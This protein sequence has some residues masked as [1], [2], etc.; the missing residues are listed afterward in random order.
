MFSQAQYEAVIREIEN[1][2]RTLEAKLAEVHPAARKAKGQWWITPPAAMAIEW[3]AEKTVEVGKAILN[4]F[5]DLLKGAVAPIFMFIDAYHWMDIRGSANAVSTDLT[6][7][8]LVVDNSDW[9]GAGHDAYLTTAGA[10]SSAASRVGSIATSTSINL[11]ACAAA[12]LAFY[13]ALAGVLAKL[14]AALAVV[15]AA[16]GSVVFSWAGLALFLEEAGVNTAIIVTAVATLGAFLGAQATA[17]IMLHGDAVDPSGF[18]EGVW[19]KSNTAQYSD[20]SVLD[21]DAD[22]SLKSE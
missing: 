3:I 1:G 13:V 14:I 20:A 15:I 17:M 10:Q 5:L 11:L 7:Q 8:N 16:F 12:G 9:S 21:G 2:T 6:T 22:W 19:P 4:W 18:P